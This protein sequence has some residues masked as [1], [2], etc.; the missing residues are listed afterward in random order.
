MISVSLGCFSSC[1]LPFVAKSPVHPSSSLTASEQFL[2]VTWD[3]VSG[4]YVLILPPIKFNSQT[5]RLYF[6]SQRYWE[7]IHSLSDCLQAGTLVFGPGTQA[8]TYIIGFPGLRPLESDQT[9][10][11]AGSTGCRLQIWGPSQFQSSD[12]H[13][14]ANST[15]KYVMT[16]M[17]QL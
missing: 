7:F 4:A 6:L 15:L 13:V 10:G 11:Y 9:W 3:A 14:S 1:S 17:Q 5:F 8:G 12:V 16:H 2:R